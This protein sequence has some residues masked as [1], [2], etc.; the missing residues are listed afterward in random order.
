VPELA[1]NKVSVWQDRDKSDFWCLTG[2]IAMVGLAL[3]TILPLTSLQLESQGLDSFQIGLVIAVHALG[4]VSAIL[5][6]ETSTIQFGARNTIQWFG[7]ASAITGAV[8][9]YLN[10]PLLFATALFFLGVFLGVV[11][12]M[13]E[14][15]VNEVIPESQRGRWL[16]IHCTIF[17]LFQ[18][19][20]PVLVQHMPTQFAFTASAG[21][22]LLGWPAYRA[23]SSR[24]IGSHDAHTETA[25]AWAPLLVS[26]PVIVVS[27]AL[28]ALFD[29]I[30]LSLLPIYGMAQGMPTKMALLSASVVLAGDTL[31][32]IAVGLLA[33]RFGRAKIHTLC[34]LVLLASALLLPLSIGSLLWWPLLFLMG[35]TAG[36]IYV[37]SMMACGQ[38]FTGH[39]LLRMTALLGSVWGVA[40]IVGPL[41][42]GS[43]MVHA[44]VWSIP[45]VVMAMAASL[46]TA[47]VYER[48]SNQIIKGVVVEKSFSNIVVMGFGNIGQ[49]L[50]SLLRMRFVKENILVIDELMNPDQ[51]SVAA[52]YRMEVLH[53]RITQEN[54]ISVLSP[55]VGERTLVLNLATS[56]GSRDLIAWTQARKA[57]Y[58]DT[59]IDPWEYQDGV[60]DNSTNTNYEMRETV[61]ALMR[62]AQESQQLPASTAIVGHGA[63]PGFVSILVKEGLLQMQEKFR[64]SREVPQT[65]QAWAELAQQLGLRVIQVSERDSQSTSKP[66]QHGEFVNTWSVDGYVAEALQPAE[67]GWGTHEES[68]PLASQ[69]G[70]HAGGCQAAVYL[71]HMGAHCDVKSWAPHAVNS[72]VI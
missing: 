18:L 44:G 49:A 72:P 11:L 63:N 12:N 66:R 9:Q 30:V 6:C 69:V 7:V 8:M 23:L 64:A 27:T 25:I 52:R 17:T 53:C 34:A 22:L 60:I 45:V 42:T 36:G 5:V 47:L 33:D 3:G 43:L 26:S 41:A 1:I 70:R 35:G 46:L 21:L 65:R 48:F 29:T 13:V 57:F 14:T 39:H 28:F 4:L 20:G 58:L 15:W 16:A 38:R 56:I 55:L 67:L 59:C 71:R 61:L 68:G 37:L 51:R 2:A 24:Q 50:S 54:Y 32:E 62:E 19:A 10:G 31:L 40:S